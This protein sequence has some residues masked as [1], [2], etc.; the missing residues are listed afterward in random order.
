MHLSRR[1]FLTASAA[2]IALPKPS[3]AA[4]VYLRAEPVTAQIL[5][6]GDGTTQML[7]FNG[8][9][10]GPELR[11]RQGDTVDLRF[12]NAIGQGS[13]VHWHGVRIDNAMDGVPSLTQPLVED[14]DGFDYRFDLPD[15]GTY[16]YHSHN[17]SWEQVA[18]GLYGPLIVEEK[19]PPAV[20]H[21]ITV[22][23]DDWRVERSG[24]M[25]EDFGNRHDFSHAGRL[26]TFA[27]VIP[28]VNTVRR[29]DRVRLRL[30]NVATARVFPLKISGLSGKIV[31]LD[32]MPLAAPQEIQSV[33]LAPA[34]RM[35]I[36]ADVSETVKFVFPTRQ[37]PYEMGQIAVEG[38]NPNPHT[39][40]IGALPSA[41]TAQPDPEPTHIVSLTL[42]GGAMGGRHG[43]DDIWSLNGVSGLQDAPWK[44]FV[45]GETV[46]ITIKN[47]TAFPHGMHLHG[48]HFHEI[49]EDG[50]LGPLRDTTLLQRQQNRDIL[51][52]F[53]NPGKWLLHCH[54]LGHQASGM[55]TWIEVG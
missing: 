34:Q 32:G 37:E 44:R 3:L 29:G 5:P 50:A 10:P 28:S 27:K 30:I 21:D 14:G 4:P 8:S 16:W 31:A 7:G 12:E 17:R 42:Q 46:R 1:T 13:A 38:T 48:H 40:E 6:P 33:M 25:I 9:T 36:I 41:A 39:D 22:M 2:L 51:C 49:A 55:K 23:V 26:G 52:V 11:Y 19:N 54:M 53:D 24:E 15:A 18:R 43:G 47:E 45:L 35:D 20:D